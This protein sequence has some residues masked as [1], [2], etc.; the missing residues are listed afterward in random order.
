MAVRRTGQLSIVGK[1][2]QYGSKNMVL[3]LNV[4]QDGMDRG[5][6]PA[7]AHSDTEVAAFL[8]G[9]LHRGAGGSPGPHAAQRLKHGASPAACHVGKPV[10]MQLVGGGAWCCDGGVQQAD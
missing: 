8:R 2:L 10:G 9:A 7:E 5:G 1:I 6:P 3:V 4:H